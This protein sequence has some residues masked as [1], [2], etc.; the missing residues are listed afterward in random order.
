VPPRIERT[1]GHSWG[2]AGRLNPDA[3]IGAP[4]EFDAMSDDELERALIERM[5]RLGF[6]DVGRR[7]TEFVAFSGTLLCLSD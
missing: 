2:R 3:E 6:T 1:S 5:A 7:S 4:G